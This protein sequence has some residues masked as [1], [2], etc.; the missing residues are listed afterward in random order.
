MDKILMGIG[1]V[2]LIVVVL[3]V[4]SVLV[5]YPVMLII[6]YLF[7]ASFLRM[8]FGVPDLGFWQAFWLSVLCGSLFKS[9]SSS[10]D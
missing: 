9:S 10:K 5:A 7:A 4:V 6:N 1:A 2:A 8:V 3:V